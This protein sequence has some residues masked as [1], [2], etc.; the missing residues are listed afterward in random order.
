MTSTY[1]D[2]H[3]IVDSFSKEAL[4][5]VRSHRSSQRAGTEPQSQKAIWQGIVKDQDT[6]E[7]LGLRAF[8]LVRA[9]ATQAL[10]LRCFTVLVS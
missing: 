4:V 9:L 1:S 3:R 5:W 6:V 8:V 2:R 7:V 10:V